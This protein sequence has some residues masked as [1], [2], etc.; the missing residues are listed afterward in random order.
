MAII[1][2]TIF[3]SILLLT[4]F[5]CKRKN[6]DNQTVN[7][8][9]ELAVEAGQDIKFAINDNIKFNFPSL[10]PYID[11]NGKEYL[12]LSCLN[13]SI[14]FYDLLTGEY[15]FETKLEA[16]GPNGVGMM[17]GFYIEDFNN[18][19]ITSYYLGI[20]KVDTSGVKK[21]FIEYRETNTGY[22]IVPNFTSS[23]FIYIPIVIHNGHIHITQ[24]PYGVFKASE[25][26]VSAFIDTTSQI[27]N[28][29]PFRFPTIISDQQLP[30]VATGLRF[31]R[32]F[33]GESFVFS[34]FMDESIYVTDLYTN[35]VKKIS[36][37]SKYVNDLKFVKLSNDRERDYKELLETSYYYNLLY[38]KYRNVYYRFAIIGSEVSNNTG[39]NYFD[40]YR[41]GLVKFSV[42]VLDKDFNIIGETLF[43]K[44]TYDPTIAFV[45]KNGL[46][47]S[48]SHIL[49][50]SFDENTLSFKCFTLKEMNN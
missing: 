36:A 25:T 15:L 20:T 12:T 43:P 35:E 23:S 5:S 47:I 33:N 9:Y 2:K 13:N 32:E 26:P 1:K 44:Y 48:D 40:I 21:Q 31:S 50:P 16:E 38:D 30:Q 24:L 46:Y 7:Y 17:S 27:I 42:I 19:Y 41:N 8:K 18:I 3:L 6:T 39:Y 34:F 29:H 22:N 14:L 45:H 28:E 37:K 10:F 4:C 49:N 11:K